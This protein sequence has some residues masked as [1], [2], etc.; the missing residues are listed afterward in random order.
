MGKKSNLT[1]SPTRTKN[2]QT[3]APQLARLNTL[4][5]LIKVVPRK[6]L[7]MSLFTF[8]LL[9]IPLYVEKTSC[10]IQNESKHFRHYRLVIGDNLRSL[11]VILMKS[12]V[13]KTCTFIR[14]KSTVIYRVTG[15]SR[16]RDRN[17]WSANIDNR[18]QNLHISCGPS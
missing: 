14:V 17:L 6:P 9:E 8:Y 11:A 12:L 3:Y 7:L 1:L 18:E 10:E 16:V 5:L 2:N 13:F 15:C 4:D